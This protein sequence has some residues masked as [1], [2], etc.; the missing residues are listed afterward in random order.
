MKEYSLVPI[1][2]ETGDYNPE[3][4]TGGDP[5]LLNR[6]T[7]RPNTNESTNDNKRKMNAIKQNIS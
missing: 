6:T 1:Y 4:V 5:S 3:V 2:W 7:G